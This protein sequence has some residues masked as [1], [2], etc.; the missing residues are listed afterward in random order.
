MPIYMQ[1]GAFQ[2][3]LQPTGQEKWIEISSFQWS[4]ARGLT[5]S[6]ANQS[7]REGS[8][9]SIG[10]IVVTKPTDA[11]SSRL[12]RYLQLGTKVLVSIISGKHPSGKHASH[13][14]NLAGASI[15]SI[16]PLSGGPKRREKIAIRFTGHTYNGV[17][18][19][20][21]PHHLFHL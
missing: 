9:P 10:E 14:V 4:V 19:I 15:V 6:S 12:S 2:A 16:Q 3:E 18:N 17:P 1:F 20:P 21:V 11:S 5:Q 8:A 7:D 13:S